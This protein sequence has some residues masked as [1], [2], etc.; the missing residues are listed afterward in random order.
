MREECIVKSGSRHGLF[1]RYLV[2]FLLVLTVPAGVIGVCIWGSM[3]AALWRE[4]KSAMQ[5]ASQQVVSVL[6]Q[7]LVG[8][9]SLAVM[10]VTDTDVRTMT[11][12][13][14][15]DQASLEKHEGVRKLSAYKTPNAF[16][17]RIMVV[18]GDRLLSNEGLFMAWEEDAI[19]QIVAEHGAGKFAYRPD[20][21]PEKIYYLR[22][23]SILRESDQYL[24]CEIPRSLFDGLAGALP[25]APQVQ[26]CV[27]EGDENVIYSSA[28]GLAAFAQPEQGE[29]WRSVRYDACEYMLYVARLETMDVRVLFFVPQ[30]LASAPLDH[31]LRV[32]GTYLMLAVLLGIALSLC[33][34]Y[35]NYK[36][37]QP[38]LQDL[39]ERDETGFYKNRALENITLA[40]TKT[41][42]DNLRLQE[43]V[44]RES[45]FTARRFML[46]VLRGRYDDNMN[47]E[48]AAQQFSIRFYN[49]RFRVLLALVHRPSSSPWEGVDDENVQEMLGCAFVG[50]CQLSTLLVEPGLTALV[51]NYEPIQLCENAIT[52]GAQSVIRGIWER[53]GLHATIGVS[54]EKESLADLHAAYTQAENACEYRL[55]RG[56]DQVI[57]AREVE[58]LVDDISLRYVQAFRN[59]A[60]IQRHLE[61][62][63]Y[64]AIEAHI[65]HLFR[66]ISNCSMSVSLVRCLYYEIINMV[67]RTLPYGFIRTVD[68]SNLVDVDTMEEL[69]AHVLEIYARACQARGGP[70]EQKGPVEHA[71]DYIHEHYGEYDLSLESV[72]AAQ[73]LSRS[74]LSRL[75]SE[76][77]SVTL[78]EYVGRL[79]VTRACALMRD[80]ELSVA[81]VA[82]QVGYQDLHTFL[83]NFKKYTHMTPTQYREQKMDATRR[84]QE[85]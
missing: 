76:R 61:E 52:Q 12:V 82:Q 56:N 72:A 59:Q 65:N 7:Y 77:M 64:G 70:K 38:L 71:L 34:A 68:V 25:H 14:A 19:V 66:E 78:S 55:I 13:M 32:L 27:L 35:R 57:L 41:K 23:L 49:P 20:L 47:L 36:P 67:L 39:D 1:F 84:P 58:G 5:A 79:R 43:R 21:M 62:G 81:Q 50:R 18:S 31:T 80:T 42:R 48:Q 73:G 29:Q 40:Y 11:S 15:S 83:R 75:F 85:E 8:M 16:I 33:F 10:L 22:R 30:S 60:D 74:Y 44:M 54:E 17:D 53:Y 2:M 63:N 4:I 69:R 46:N 26:M 45:V 6:E 24:L 9:E 28:E 37:L 3:R 51:L